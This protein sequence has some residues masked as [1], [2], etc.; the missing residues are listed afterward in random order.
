VDKFPGWAPGARCANSQTPK[1]PYETPEI[2]DSGRCTSVT[3]RDPVNFRASFGIKGRKTGKI[4]SPGLDFRILKAYI[5][6]MQQELQL[7]V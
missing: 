2:W 5:T 6:R 7:E 1:L 3:G 4:F